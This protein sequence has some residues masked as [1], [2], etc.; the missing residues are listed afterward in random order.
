MEPGLSAGSYNFR[1]ISSLFTYVVEMFSIFIIINHLLE[2][3]QIKFVVRIKLNQVPGSVLYTVN[4]LITIRKY[5]I[6][7]FALKLRDSAQ[8]VWLSS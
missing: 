1:A 5:Y 2:G 6:N 8:P 3:D 4:N 7:R